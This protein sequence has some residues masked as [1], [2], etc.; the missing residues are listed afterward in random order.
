MK[1]SRGVNDLLR[2]KSMVL[3]NIF[4]SNLLDV[5]MHLYGE[6]LIAKAI[7]EKV[8]KGV[9]GIDTAQL[10]AEVALNVNDHLTTYP[11]NCLKYIAVIE[12]FDAGLAREMEQ[13]F[14]GEL[15]HF[16]QKFTPFKS[17][18]I[19]RYGSTS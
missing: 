16:E 18:N 12:E 10:S 6:G 14:E 11:Y 13:K 8:V 2:K 17:H 7:Y 5:T 9:T 1:F 15:T 4:K 19:K 3:H